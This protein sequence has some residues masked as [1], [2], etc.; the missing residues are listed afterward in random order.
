MPEAL[1]AIPEVVSTVAN[2]AGAASGIAS[3]V[4]TAEQLSQPSQAAANG[5]T[6]ALPV[7]QGFGGFGGA[8]GGISP[9]SSGDL[10]GGSAVGGS[11]GQFNPQDALGQLQAL[12]NA[13]EQ[14]QL[15]LGE[16]KQRH[17]EVKSALQAIGS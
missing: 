2:L 13:D 9:F 5:A 8:N 1:A 4:Q 14:F 11:G 3:T 6:N 15:Q 16:E 17:S 12:N 10:G 7:P